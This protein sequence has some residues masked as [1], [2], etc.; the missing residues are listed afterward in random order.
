MNAF[1][2][3]SSPVQTSVLCIA[4]GA[5]HLRLH[6]LDS[7]SKEGKPHRL[8]LVADVQRSETRHV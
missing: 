1:H 8:F 3:P 5:A 4:P 6:H 7:T 2:A